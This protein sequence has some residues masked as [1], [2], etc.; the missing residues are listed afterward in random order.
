MK[1]ADLLKPPTD[2]EA[3][4]LQRDKLASRYGKRPTLPMTDDR[5]LRLPEW[6]RP[7]PRPLDE[8]IAMICATMLDGIRAPSRG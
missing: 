7:G 8:I 3:A 2:A 4:D 5:W 6:V 1:W